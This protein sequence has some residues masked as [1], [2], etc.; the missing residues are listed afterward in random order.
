MNPREQRGIELAEATQISRRSGDVWAVP[1]QNGRGRYW[2]KLNGDKPPCTCPDHEIRDQ[3]CKYIFAVEH[4]LKQETKPDGTTTVTETLQWSW[5]S[6]NSSQTEEKHRFAV[7]L[8]TLCRGVPEPEQTRGRPHLPLSDMVFA[9]ALKIYCG[10]SSR[11]FT[12][13]L[14]DAQANGLIKSTPHFNS[15]SLYLSDPQLRTS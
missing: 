12:T 1:S 11:R 5:T 2:V 9:A 6:Y 7:L 4:T 8:S 13:D 15:V 14:R 10:F 3:K